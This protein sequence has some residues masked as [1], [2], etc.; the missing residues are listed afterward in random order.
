MSFQPS[1][2]HHHKY[3]GGMV[4]FRMDLNYSESDPCFFHFFR[5]I[6][7]TI[8][9]PLGRLQA[10]TYIATPLAAESEVS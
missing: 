7:L 8:L 3:I 1:P 4:T 9:G 6:N 2:S 10:V 5:H